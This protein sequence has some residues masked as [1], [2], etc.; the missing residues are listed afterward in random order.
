MEQEKKKKKK[1]LRTYLYETKGAARERAGERF[2]L[3]QRVCLC[4]LSRVKKKKRV[5]M[6]HTYG[7]SFERW[8]EEPS[9]Q[10]LDS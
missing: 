9:A 10:R 6:Y 4:T 1:P 2:L 3:I 8:R 5:I 7:R